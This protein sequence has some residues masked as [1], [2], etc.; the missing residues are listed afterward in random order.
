MSFAHILLIYLKLVQSSRLYPMPRIKARNKTNLTV[1][2]LWDKI[3]SSLYFL[4]ENID[5]I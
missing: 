1:I 4:C 3:G 2:M 5:I